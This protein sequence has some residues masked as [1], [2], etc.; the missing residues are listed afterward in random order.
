MLAPVLACLLLIQAVPAFAGGTDKFPGA[1]LSIL[2]PDDAVPPDAV[3]LK[4]ISLS[5]NSYGQDCAYYELLLK[6][7]ELAA[8]AGANILKIKAKAPHSRSQRCDRI[9]VAFY[10]SADPRKAEQSFRWHSA[11]QLNWDDFKGPVRAGS[12]AR[13]AAE[14]SCGIAVET[15]LVVNSG[16]ARVFVFNTF[17]KRGSWVRAG[18]DL[19]GVLEH[20]Q[21]HW[22]ICELYT[23]RMQ[24]RFDEQQITGATLNRKVNEIYNEVSREYIERQEQYEQDTQ[25]GMVA[26]QQQHWT[27]LIAGELQQK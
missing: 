20:E 4:E 5:G 12:G 15:S 1:I 17:D 14:T 27:R 9:E 19:P 10:Q 3:K 13:T 11:R 16:I 25:H 6:A 7:K 2:Q 26:E 18:K 22:D 21:G 24:A 8:E 23:R